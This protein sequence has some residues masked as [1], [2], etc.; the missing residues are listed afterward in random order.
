MTASG[1]GQM[2]GAW[3]AWRAGQ[4]A[5]RDTRLIDG[6]WAG[7]VLIAVAGAA[8]TALAWS[9]FKANDAI[10]NIGA[11]ASTVAYAS[12]GALIVRRVRN[13][14]GWLLLIAGAG[15]GMTVCFS[16]YA[17]VGIVAH[18]GALPAA[19]QVG[20]VAEWVFSP[21]VAA[22]VGTLLLFPTGTLPS[23]RWRPV[24]VLNFVATGLLMIGFI[25]LLRPVALPAPGGYSLTYQNP[26]GIPAAGRALSALHITNINSLTVVSVLFLGAA[27]VS[28]VLRYRAG[29][30]EL[31]RQINWVALAG[32]AGRPAGPP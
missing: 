4:T 6:M 20:A 14:I 5:R 10:S 3:I 26:F 25:L 28:L 16:S 2:A 8:L 1:D 22:L 21:V 15:I 17:V 31:R 12:L 30:A 23:R 7:A 9:G 18:P 11:S 24:A 29:G 19:E 27:A 13:P 32:V